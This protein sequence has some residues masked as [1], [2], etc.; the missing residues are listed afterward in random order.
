MK[1]L[2]ISIIA[3]LL[4]AQALAHPVGIPYS[5]RGECEAAYAASSKLDR[6]RLTGYGF[7]PGEAQSTFRDLFQCQYDPNA[8][9]WY[10]VYIGEF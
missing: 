5:S 10:I 8:D 3:L 7:T 6:E 1:K 2:V 4:P 9:K